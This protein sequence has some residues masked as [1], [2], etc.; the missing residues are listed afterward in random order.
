MNLIGCGGWV[1]YYYFL[2]GS[3]ITKLLK[4][5]IFGFGKSFQILNNLIISKHKFLIVF[6]S[7]FSE[8]L[9]GLIIC[10]CLIIS[11]RAY[12][13]KRIKYEKMKNEITTNIISNKKKNKNNKNNK[14]IETPNQEVELI[15]KDNDIE[16]ESNG[17][18]QN[19]IND[20]DINFNQFSDKIN[21]NEE[22]KVEEMNITKMTQNSQ[23]IPKKFELI[24]ND[25]YEDNIEVSFSSIVLSSF[26]LI[27]YDIVI[28]WIFSRNEIFDYYFIN[29]LIMALIFKFH[30]KEDIYSHQT[31][32]LIIIL[33]IAGALFIACLFE[34]IDLSVGN[35]TIWEAFGENHY[36]IF[37]FIIIYFISSMCSCYGTIIQKRIM[38]YQFVSP[39]QIIFYKGLLGV[40]ISI[41]LI[42]ISTY[43]P[44]KESQFVDLNMPNIDSNINN[45]IYLNS[46]LSSNNNSSPPLFECIDN[47]NNKS[48]FDNFLSYYNSIKNLEN[49]RDKYLELFLSIPVYCILHFITNVLLIFVNK[50][51]SPIHC[52]IVDSIYRVLHIPIQ[53]L[54]KIQIKGNYEGFFYEFIIQPLSTR[55]LRVLAHFVSII[56]YCIYLE[57]IEL[58]FCG[59]NSNIRKNIKKRAKSDGNAKEYLSN[60][61]ISSNSNASNDGED[62]ERESFK[63]N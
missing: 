21:S 20:D 41:I 28:K 15:I 3:A 33:F 17:I 60:Y 24:H 61:S 55:I 49:K 54:Q 56:G 9:F 14:K 48:Y 53:S 39:Y 6:I 1:S 5:D 44:C 50:L 63:N 30:Y 13:K 42:N 46:N 32:A 27:V 58:K 62:E 4:E 45:I 59:L 26:L 11:E 38:D 12:I 22:K 2:I 37:I 40:I 35:K 7:Y 51:L 10:I 36:M 8:L 18:N 31:L 29:I 52:L 19:L 16:K 57:I 34:N 47:Y 25:K 23:T 43:I